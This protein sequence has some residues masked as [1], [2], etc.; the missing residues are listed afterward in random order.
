MNLIAH[1][2]KNSIGEVRVLEINQP[3]DF[4]P[5]IWREGNFSCDC[6]R[7]VFFQRANGGNE[8]S[9]TPCGNGMFSINIYHNERQVYKEFEGV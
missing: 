8:K 9:N 7:S 1:I 5:W 6:N 4:H 3:D 2:K